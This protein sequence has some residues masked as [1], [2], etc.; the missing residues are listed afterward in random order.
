[1]F[2]PFLLSGVALA[3]SAC[4]G[5][6][7]SLG[8]VRQELTEAEPSAQTSVVAVLAERGLDQQLCTGVVLSPWLVLTARHCL[9]A[10]VLELEARDCDT[11][12][13]EPEPDAHITVIPGTDIDLAAPEDHAAVT[14]LWVPQGEGR[15]CGDDLV[16][17]RVNQP[18]EGPGLPLTAHQVSEGEL[19]TAIGYGLFDGDY[20]QQRMR[21]D[22]KVLCAGADCDDERLADSEFLAEAGVCGGD[23]GGPAVT[24]EGKVFAMAVRSSPSCDETAYLSLAPRIAWLAQAV[25]ELAEETDSPLPPWASLE[26]EEPESDGET[27]AV[28][29]AVIPVGGG[30]C[31]VP[32]GGVGHESAPFALLATLGLLLGRRKSR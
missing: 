11:Q 6:A 28:R 3:L 29:K 19:F 12:F 22:A 26:D 31:R 5:E 8:G 15:L 4:S 14:E 10:A 32:H 21:G 18:L 13:S 16:L 25:R 9:D 20:G 23:S 2:R 17:L 24:P 7:P 27:A 1:M 30:G